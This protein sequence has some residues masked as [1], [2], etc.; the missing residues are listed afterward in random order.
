MAA[1]GAGSFEGSALEHAPAFSR[2]VATRVA[3][4]KSSA[5]GTPRGSGGFAQSDRAR[6]LLAGFSARRAPT[7]VRAALIVEFA[8]YVLCVEIAAASW[9]TATTVARVAGAGEK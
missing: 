8:G 2:W 6:V 1:R 7:L 4:E 9:I 5:A 3:R